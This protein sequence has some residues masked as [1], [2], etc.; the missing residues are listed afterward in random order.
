MYTHNFNFL[1]QFGREIR[2][3]QYLFM[4]KKK[5]NPLTKGVDFLICYITFNFLSIGLKVDKFC[6][7]DPTALSSTNWDVTE[8]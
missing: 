3:E 5:E 6:V 2:K 8:V 7:F 1:A 4:V